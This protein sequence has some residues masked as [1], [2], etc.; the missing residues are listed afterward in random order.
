MRG[1]SGS[2][3]GLWLRLVMVRG[4]ELVIRRVMQPC[5]VLRNWSSAFLESANFL[6]FGLGF[7]MV[8]EGCRLG[9]YSGTWIP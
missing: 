4:C 6:V 2:G 8:G 7:Q 1:G 5:E 9:L 3:F